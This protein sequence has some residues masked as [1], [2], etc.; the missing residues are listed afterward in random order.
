MALRRRFF[1][2]LATLWTAFTVLSLALITIMIST[3]PGFPLGL[4]LIQTR[5]LTG[6]WVTLPGIVLGAAGLILLKVSRPVGARLLVLYS[7]FWTA[8][9][10]PGVCAEIPTVVRHPIAYCTTGTCT[11]WI[12][13]AGITVAFALSS[14]WYARQSFPRELT[15]A[16]S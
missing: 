10:L 12:I 9:L 13:T 16:R 11:P 4:G 2:V 14:V 3:E 5:G 1:L 6:L 8:T 15:A 7:G